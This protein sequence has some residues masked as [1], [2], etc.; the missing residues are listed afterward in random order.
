MSIHGEAPYIVLWTCRGLCK[1]GGGV[2]GL[3]Q[4]VLARNAHRA[5]QTVYHASRVLG[6]GDARGYARNT[7]NEEVQ[8]GSYAVNG[9]WRWVE[10][11]TVHTC[12][13]TCLAVSE[14]PC[15]PAQ[16]C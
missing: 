11:H 16:G 4:Y 5:A 7:A 13:K 8:T 2:D 9:M 12:P 6:H 10:S 1:D 15:R 3:P 14:P